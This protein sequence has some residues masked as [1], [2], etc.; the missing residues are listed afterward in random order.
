M[1]LADVQSAVAGTL[2]TGVPQDLNAIPLVGGQSPDRRL[3]IHAR[4]YA[5][6]LT[7]ALVERFPAT[8]WLIGSAAVVD[9]AGAF[10]RAHPPTAPCIAEYGE[11]FPAFLAAR[12]PH[13]SYL[14]PF[15]TLDWHLGRLA[16]ATD[17]AVVRVDIDWSV[18]EL[19]RFYLTGTA[20]D[21][22]EIRSGRACVELRGSRGDLWMQRV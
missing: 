10:I 7:A 12:V 22:Y 2:R 4:H 5:A 20:P 9:A 1:R 21:R 16:L 17:V 19:I 11:G 18:D 13:L 14:E 8:V 3:A 15:A 6:S